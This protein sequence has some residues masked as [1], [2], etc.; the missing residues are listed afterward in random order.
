[1]TQKDL[2]RRLKKTEEEADINGFKTKTMLWHLLERTDAQEQVL[3]SIKA[4][5]MTRS[6]CVMTRRHAENKNNK[7]MS[8]CI[9]GAAFVVSLIA[10]VVVLLSNFF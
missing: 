8:N 7:I 6:E 3:A 10:C 2:K 1:M 5:M 9:A 4:D